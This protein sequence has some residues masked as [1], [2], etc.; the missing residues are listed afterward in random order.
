MWS[1]LGQGLVW[2]YCEHGRESSGFISMQ[3]SY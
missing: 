3:G 2:G 1:E